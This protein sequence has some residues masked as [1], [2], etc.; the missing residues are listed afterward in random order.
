MSRP[1]ALFP[2][3][4]AMRQSENRLASSLSFCMGSHSGPVA[5]QDRACLRAGSFTGL[6]QGVGLA[7]IRR[8]V[9]LPMA[10]ST[11]FRR[12]IRLA[13]STSF[14]GCTNGVCDQTTFIG[15][16]EMI[17]VGD[18]I[19]CSPQLRRTLS[20]VQAGLA[21][22]GEQWIF[23]AL[24][25]CGTLRSSAAL[26]PCRCSISRVDPNIFLKRRIGDKTGGRQRA[27]AI[28]N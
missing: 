15:V 22:L 23:L 2:M 19:E 17:S 8:P 10:I 25:C 27:K 6:D 14:D 18:Q 16:A 3:E 1:F 4:P 26:H 28:M 21:S 20:R 11:V 9:M 24:Q 13:F 5:Q 7:G 12:F